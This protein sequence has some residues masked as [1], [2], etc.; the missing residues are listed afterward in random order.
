MKTW[1]LFT[2]IFRRLDDFQRIRDDYSYELHSNNEDDSHSL[3]SPS[4]RR[5]K[6]IHHKRRFSISIYSV[7]SFLQHTLTIRRIV[8]ILFASLFLLVVAILSSGIPSTYQDVRIYERNLPQHRI[9]EAVSEKIGRDGVTERIHRRKY[10][11]FDGALWGHGLN[12]VLQES[13]VM[14]YVAQL[15][16]RS[17]VFEDHVWS[18]SPLPYTLYDFAL[19]PSRIPMNA[20]ISGPSAGGPW[21]DGN[22]ANRAVSLEF[23]NSVCRPEERIVLSTKDAPVDASF[24]KGADEIVNWFVT[25]LRRVEDE[26]CVVIGSEGKMLFDFELFGTKRILPIFTSLLESPILA[27]FAWSPLVLSAVARNFAILQPDDLSDL[28][29]SPPPPSLPASSSSQHQSNSNRRPQS[30]VL[31]G[32][33]AVHLRRGDY[34]RHCYRLVGWDYQYMGV[35]QYEG[36]PDRFDPDAYLREHRFHSSGSGEE[37][38]S[39]MRRNSSS[40]STSSGGSSS[41]EPIG[42]SHRTAEEHS[43]LTPYYIQHCLPEIPEIVERLRQVRLEYEMSSS[44]SPSSSSPSSR[45]STTTHLSSSSSFTSSSSQKKNYKLKRIYLLSNGWGFWLSSLTKALKADGWEDVRHGGELEMDMAQRHVSMAVDM[46][47][48]EKAEMFIGN[49]I[50]ARNFGWGGAER[51]DSCVLLVPFFIPA[52]HLVCSS[53]C[54]FMRARFLYGVFRGVGGVFNV[55]SCLCL[56]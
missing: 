55:D 36:L 23:F 47:I 21:P 37:G 46:A 39:S 16:H 35:N 20:F 4:M 25:E 54:E 1:S 43:M 44:S 30:G 40:M 6:S 41:T 53:F 49:G 19:R 48:A 11:W 32:V 22:I 26:P 13:F 8:I 45:A 12:N 10:L 28:Y 50:R 14:A 15:S 52:F 29:P 24:G 38:L 9:R 56:C 42:S 34:S 5:R 51:V 3:P 18:K 2:S 7:V 27:N 33:V 31:S 17:Y